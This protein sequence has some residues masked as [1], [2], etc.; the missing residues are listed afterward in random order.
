MNLRHLVSRVL[1]PFMTDALRREEP[2]YASW[3][4]ACRAAAGTY[5]D[6]LVNRFRVDRAALQAAEPDAALANALLLTLMAIAEPD[7]AIT[8]FGGAKGRLGVG[9]L[10]YLNA[11]GGTEHTIHRRRKPDPYW[12]DGET[13]L[14][15]PIHDAGARRMRHLLLQWH[16][17][18]YRD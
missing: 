18:I 16:A 10:Q 17:S 7:A 13:S 14:A 1:P 8:D 2:T 6:E 11:G 15:H 9:L 12:A 3:A 4:E 5:N